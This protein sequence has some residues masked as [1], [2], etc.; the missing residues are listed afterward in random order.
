[1]NTNTKGYKGK[2]SNRWILVCKDEVLYLAG[3]YRSVQEVKDV[4]LK[5]KSYLWIYPGTIRK[6]PKR[7]YHKKADES[8]TTDNKGE[9]K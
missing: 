5:I 8:V 4:V 6:M 3:S 2:P 1:M 9:V 7:E